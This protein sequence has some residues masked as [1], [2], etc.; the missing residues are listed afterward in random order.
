[1][2]LNDLTVLSNQNGIT[3]ESDELTTDLISTIKEFEEITAEIESKHQTQEIRTSLDESSIISRPEEKGPIEY[4][5]RTKE[6]LRHIQ[7]KNHNES[8]TNTN[9]AEITNEIDETHEDYVKIPVQQLINTF[10]KQMRSI[11]K[12]KI[13]EN[14]QLTT[15]SNK[16]SASYINKDNI[17]KEQVTN[18]NEQFTA[19]AVNRIEQ[20]QLLH[21]TDEQ[22]STQTESTTVNIAQF[23][24][25]KQSF[26]Q[27]SNTNT[28]TTNNQFISNGVQRNDHGG[29]AC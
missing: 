20:H 19:S 16:I 28:T 25:F 14:I 8:K 15:N 9:R 26:T 11:I 1:M 17:E 3:F 27:E 13:N 24:E 22:R 23:D 29:K 21:S 12:Q 4:F 7:D 2:K 18:T 5:N 10:E 6:S